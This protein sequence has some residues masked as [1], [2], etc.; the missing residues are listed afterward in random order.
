M[1][2]NDTGGFVCFV[3]Y[4][5]EGWL[6]F[7]TSSVHAGITIRG[8]TS[9]IER[10]ICF[11]FLAGVGTYAEYRGVRCDDVIAGRIVFLFTRGI[12]WDNASNTCL[13]FFLIRFIEPTNGRFGLW[14]GKVHVFV[15]IG[16]SVAIVQ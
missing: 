5:H 10:R 13:A 8:I 12:S 6:F 2:A 7:G 14:L 15:V 11:V 16:C 9:W 1:R 4:T 3:L